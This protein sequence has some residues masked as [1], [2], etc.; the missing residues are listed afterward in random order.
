MAGDKLTWA[1][2]DSPA[3]LNNQELQLFML[4]LKKILKNKI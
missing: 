1:N 2:L 4:S 3:S